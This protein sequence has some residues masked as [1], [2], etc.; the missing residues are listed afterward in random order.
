MIQVLEPLEVRAGDTTTVDKQ[1]WGGDDSSAGEDLLGGVGGGAVGTFED[2]LDHN[3]LSVAGVKRLLSGSGDH[4]VSL[5][6]EELLGVCADGLSGTWEGCEG[7][8]LNHEVL[9][10]LNVKAIGVV[11]SGVVLNDGGDLAAVLLNELGGPVANS[12]EALHD[13]GLVLDAK[14]ET[15]T[16]NKGLSVEEL[17]HGV[18]DTET[19]RLGTASNTSL[20]DEL[21]SAAAFGIDVLLTSDIHV[22]VLDPGHDLLIGSHIGSKAIN[23]GTDKAL[24]D[25]LHSVFTSD[26]LNLWLGV[27]SGVNLDTA[28]AATEGHIGDGKFEGHQGG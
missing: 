26:S 10:I 23:L 19:S 28:L 1:V 21:A 14:V 22:S 5:L 3:V 25:E 20:G 18:V 24:L 11:N 9:D 8:V 6:K 4:A 7:T 27:L 13:E 15:T 2:G 12:T 16:C 17:T